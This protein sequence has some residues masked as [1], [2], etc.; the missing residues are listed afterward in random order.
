M[1]RSSTIGSYP[2]DIGS[3]PVS[4]IG[5]IDHMN[6]SVVNKNFGLLFSFN[7]GLGRQYYTGCDNMTFN[8]TAQ[9]NLGVAN[10]QIQY[11]G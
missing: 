9:A 6:A 7:K 4:A 10:V 11:D 5:F 8:V 1:Y 2:I 3:N